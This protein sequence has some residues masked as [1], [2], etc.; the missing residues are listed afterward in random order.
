MYPNLDIPPSPPGSPN[1]ST[2]AKITHFMRLKGQ[3]I[4]FNTKLASSSALKNTSL[5]PK[6]VAAA[7]IGDDVDRTQRKVNVVGDWFKQYA[8]SLPKEVWDP[9]ALPAWAYTEELD[10]AQSEVGKWR[11]EEKVG[12]QR[13][14]I[15]V[16]EKR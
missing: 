7:G 10:Q 8:T 11:Q 14:F 4:H 2:D 3:E 1:P 15:A 6:L 13:D 12:K 16:K 9:N 5:L